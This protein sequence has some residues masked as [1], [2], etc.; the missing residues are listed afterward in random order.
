MFPFDF[1][2]NENEK[3]GCIY[4]IYF[5]DYEYNLLFPVFR[6]RDH[7]VMAIIVLLHTQLNVC[8]NS[9]ILLNSYYQRHNYF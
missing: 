6:K 1:N 3:P 4:K 9:A 5:F 2:N 7:V 8:G